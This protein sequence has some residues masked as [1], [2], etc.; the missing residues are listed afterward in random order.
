MG[1][2]TEPKTIAESRTFWERFLASIGG[3]VH[4][5]GT[6]EP[7][8]EGPKILLGDTERCHLQVPQSADIWSM[9]CVISEVAT[10]VTEGCP[11]LFEYR[12][13]RQQEIAQKSGVSSTGEDRF[14]HVSEVL[15]TVKA[16]HAE[17]EHNSRRYDYITP[18]VVEKLVKAMVRPHPYHRGAAQFLLESATE[19]LKDAR[20]KQDAI[21][22]GP[23]PNP[24]HTISDSAIDTKEV[25]HEVHRHSTHKQTAILGNKVLHRSRTERGLANEAEEKVRTP[26]RTI[27]KRNVSSQELLIHYIDSLPNQPC[28]IYRASMTHDHFTRDPPPYPLGLGGAY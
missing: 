15:E 27:S 8:S 14:H 1:T 26:L 17:I 22:N 16:I 23:A 9:G 13:R 4:I 24:N 21:R 19:I 28:L 7:A 25:R 2:T 12:R 3:L 11:K 18:C 6:H 5:H 10:W 20:R